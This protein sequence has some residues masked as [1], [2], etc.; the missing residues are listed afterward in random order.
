MYKTINNIRDQKGFT[1]IELLIVVAIIGILAAIAVPAYLGQR[2]KAKARCVEAGA[3]GAVSEI[4]AY[5]DAWVEGA[6]FIAL[7]T[8]AVETCFESTTPGNK[9]CTAYYPSVSDTS[10]YDETDIDSIV[11]IVVAHHQEKNELNCFYP[12][13]SLFVK[14]TTGEAGSVVI[15]TAGTRSIS[16]RGYADSDTVSIFDTTI[17]SM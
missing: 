2:E 7:D 10:T 8:G 13:L 14:Q 5:M 16:I 11:D 6:P 3:K 12:N 4:Q 15:Y 17:T 1:L 9:T